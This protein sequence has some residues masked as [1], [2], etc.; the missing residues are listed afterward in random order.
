MEMGISAISR[1]SEYSALYFRFQ[2]FV[3]GNID[4]PLGSISRIPSPG[5]IVY[6][7]LIVFHT[8]IITL[9]IKSKVRLTQ[10][11]HLKGDL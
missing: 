11:Y 4:H 9:F 10:K 8:L 5:K 6:D 2:S 3:F 7:E 1:G